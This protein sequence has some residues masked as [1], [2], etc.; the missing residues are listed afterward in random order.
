MKKILK[1]TGLAAVLVGLGTSVA[2]ADLLTL[3][4]THSGVNYASTGIGGLRGVGSGNLTLTGVPAGSVSA[5]YLYWHGHGTFTDF[6]LY[7]GTPSTAV[8]DG[9]PITGQSVS[10][11]APNLWANRYPIDLFYGEAFRV[12]VTGIVNQKGSGTY[13]F[14]NVFPFGTN[15]QGASLLVF[16]TDPDSSK[17]N[18]TY[19][20]FNGNDCTESSVF[21]GV[22]WNLSMPGV[23][24][25][26][27]DDAMLELHVSDGQLYYYES[28]VYLNGQFLTQPTAFSPYGNPLVNVF[29][30]T[31]PYDHTS[32]YDAVFFTG[33]LY[34]VLRFDINSFLPA[35]GNNL[36]LSTGFAD[37]AIS[38]IL[39]VV[40]V[41]A[42]NGVPP[43]PPPPPPPANAPPTIAFPRSIRIDCAPAAGVS[44]DIDVQVADPDGTPLTVTWNVDGF[45]LQPVTVAGGGPPTTA[46][47]RL[48][49]LLSP[50][51]H[52]VSATVSDGYLSASGSVSVD[53][54]RD[55]TPPTVSCPGDITLEA[56]ATGQAAVP[57]I[58]A[59]VTATDQCGGVALVQDPAPGTIVAT[60]DTT[61][62]V[63]GT[64]A[65]GNV[66]RCTTTLHVNARPPVGPPPVV[67]CGVG[68]DT[69][70][71]PNHCM[72]NV[73][74]SL[75][76]L[77]VS[78]PVDIK[79]YSNEPD[80]TA[81]GCGT[82]SPDA[83]VSNGTEVWVRGERQGDQA[84]HTGRVY[85]IVASG[86][87]AQGQTASCTATV[88]V[89]HDM[90]AA[91]RRQLQAQATAAEAYFA[92]HFVPPPDFVQ[93]GTGPVIGP[94]QI[95]T[96]A[97]NAA[98]RDDDHDSN[99]N[100]KRRSSGSGK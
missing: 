25:T 69:L 24:Y 100:C 16:F 37:D 39:A 3:F 7:F 2:T 53:V 10:V 94:K 84:S 45:P 29:A 79:V 58:L 12:D 80:V 44:V 86:Q 1:Q 27:G 50:Q 19:S 46:T 88:G 51:L 36:Q 78:A 67:E 48:T 54:Y 74:L 8:F 18:G 65:S 85:L 41:R 55:K 91:A 96:T 32:A 59:Q 75:Q 4:T 61:I 21:D 82:F 64:D 73:G 62:T 97:K 49:L 66:A 95:G 17:N 14:G 60:G 68:C 83:A 20:V 57:D 35:L 81:T 87:N 30:G 26:P 89:P 34:D 22:G 71:P 40:G 47:V 6:N 77:A 90:S 70:W 92:L 98:A 28:P 23:N 15:V 13:S 43:E 72:V 9:T 42:G 11:S 99:G 63:T 33:S 5:A 38:L 93:V 76:A 52:S 56:D 31:A